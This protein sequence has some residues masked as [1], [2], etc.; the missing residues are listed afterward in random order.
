LINPFSTFRKALKRVL[1]AVA[2]FH[3][4]DELAGRD[5]GTDLPDLTHLVGDIKRCSGWPLY[6]QHP[7]K[8]YTYLYSLEVS[9]N[10]FD[11]EAS[12]LIRE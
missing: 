11:P 10:P 3:L 9:E 1:T 7:K 2:V 5:R 12:V 4:H 8:H 6:L